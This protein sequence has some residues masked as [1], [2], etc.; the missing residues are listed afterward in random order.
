MSPTLGAS[1]RSFASYLAH[2]QVRAIAPTLSGGVV[3]GLAH[4]WPIG[5]ISQQQVATVRIGQ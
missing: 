2:G 5:N 1:F 3:I 4:G